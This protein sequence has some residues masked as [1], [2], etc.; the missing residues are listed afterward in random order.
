M[1][2]VI[3]KLSLNIES[4][5]E[6]LRGAAIFLWLSMFSLMLVPDIFSD[7]SDS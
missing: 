5:D 1:S 3:E 2:G 4:F 6:R 7:D